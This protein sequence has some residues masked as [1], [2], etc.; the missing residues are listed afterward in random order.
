[1]NWNNKIGL[2]VLLLLFL[3][4]KET[5]ESTVIPAVAW[6]INDVIEVET[7]SKIKSNPHIKIVDLRPIEEYK[8]GHIPG[9]LPLSREEMSDSANPT[10]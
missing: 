1:M 2:L 4:C 5:T 7:L 3:G 8:E 10:P 6:K 9:A